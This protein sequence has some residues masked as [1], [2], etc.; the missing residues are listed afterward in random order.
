VLIIKIAR[1]ESILI[2]KNK[3]YIDSFLKL[4]NPKQI[5]NKWDNKELRWGKVKNSKIVLN[6]GSKPIVG[7]NRVDGLSQNIEKIIIE[8]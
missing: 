3:R 1:S 4:E 5:Q 6:K 7:F 2:E 8:N